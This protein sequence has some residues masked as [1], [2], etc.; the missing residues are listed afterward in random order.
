MQI[1]HDDNVDANVYLKFDKLFF[2]KKNTPPDFLYGNL[3]TLAIW[4]RNFI[5]EEIAC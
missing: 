3:C 1:Y 4:M 2:Q 5:K